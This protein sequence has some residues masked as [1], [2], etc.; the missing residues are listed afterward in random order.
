MQQTAFFVL[1]SEFSLHLFVLHVSVMII[2]LTQQVLVQHEGTFAN[3]FKV[4][5]VLIVQDTMVIKFLQ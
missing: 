2:F 3:L 4:E 1:V 5:L